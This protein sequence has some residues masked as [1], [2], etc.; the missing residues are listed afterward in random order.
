VA[1]SEPITFAFKGKTAFV[2]IQTGDV[3]QMV[4]NHA[5][6]YVDQTN[7]AYRD[8]VV[9]A[10]QAQLALKQEALRR[11]IREEESRAEVLG[12]LRL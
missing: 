10:Q 4:V 12:R 1:G 11:Q 9:R 8:M 6:N 2:P 7:V 3:A 5:K